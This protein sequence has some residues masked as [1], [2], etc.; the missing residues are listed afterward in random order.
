MSDKIGLRWHV[1][2]AELRVD[3]AFHEPKLV[4]LACKL[5][6]E[7]FAETLQS[8]GTNTRKT[9]LTEPFTA[10][11][12][13]NSF[14]IPLADIEGFSFSGQHVRVTPEI[15]VTLDDGV[16]WDTKERVN[17]QLPMPPRIEDG[18]SSGSPAT[19]LNPSDQI[20]FARN[21]GALPMGRRLLLSL[22]ILVFGVGTLCL[23]GVSLH[24]QFA[25]QSVFFPQ[26]W[27]FPPIII[28][29][30]ATVFSVFVLAFSYKA[31]LRGY[32][33]AGLSEGLTRIDGNSR[34]RVSDLFVATART[35]LTGVKVRVVA[36]SLECGEYVRRSGTDTSYISFRRPVK[37]MVLYEKTTAAVPANVDLQQYFADDL[38]FG[39]MFA[40]LL[41][42]I[43]YSDRHGI[44]LDLKMQIVVPDLADFE[45]PIPLER[46]D[47]AA[48]GGAV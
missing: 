35:S 3:V 32:M 42:P 15:V 27:D 2:G 34:L 7:M 6:I 43:M 14:A 37:A 4:G 13:G 30:L 29:I 38:D 48:F 28:G 39:P 5:T 17:F 11:P 31:L 47:I 20:S 16:L 18:L 33:T 44:G 26:N 40:A 24:D 23:L 21:F 45:L 22:V 12:Q 1:E 8:N 36:G 41:P 46:V 25:N 9:V 19:V 10:N